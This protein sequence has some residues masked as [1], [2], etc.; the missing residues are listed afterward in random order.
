MPYIQG[1]PCTIG[2]DGLGENMVTSSTPQSGGE[3]YKIPF[4]VAYASLKAFK[5]ALLGGIDTSAGEP[6][7]V[8]PFQCPF[9]PNLYCLSIESVTGI[10]PRVDADGWPYYDKAVVVAVFGAPPY[11]FTANDPAGLNDP[12]GSPWTTTTIKSSAEV[13]NPPAGS[14]YVGPFGSSAKVAEEASVGIITPTSEVAM[15]RKMLPRL[16]L[17]DLMSFQGTVNADPIQIADHVFDRGCL[18]CVSAEHEP[19]FD[20]HGTPCTDVPYTFLGK[21]HDWNQV[22]SGDGT[23]QFLNTKQDGSGTPPYAYD[24]FSQLP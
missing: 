11:Q 5:F 12:S 18:L 2:F 16:P 21:D 3:T 10:K 14:Y 20:P 13:V 15:T 9:N 8:P 19:A 24:D 7:R 1:I 22:I 17:D 6:A 23:L 4:K